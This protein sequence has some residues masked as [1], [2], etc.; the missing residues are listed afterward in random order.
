MNSIDT[1]I[2]IIGAG[3][4][5]LSIA[6]YLKDAGKNVC[7]VESQDRLGGRIQS[8][9]FESNKPLEMGATWFGAQHQSLLSLMQELGVEFFP[10]EFGTTAI[11]DAIST[12]PPFL[13]KL[14]PN[15]T[16]TY[17][18]K[19]GSMKLIT[20]LA[21][22]IQTEKIL[23]NTK[24]DKL[25]FTE[26][27]AQA[28][29]EAIIINAKTIITTLPPNLLVNT[30]NFIPALPEMFTQLAKSTHTWMSESIKFALRFNEAF[31]RSDKLSGTVYSNVGPIP[32]LYD[33]SNFEDNAHALMGFFNGAYHSIQKEERLKMILDQLAKYFGN[34]I[35]EYSSYH[36][37][38]WSKDSNIHY[39]Y[40][41]H[42]IPHQNNGHPAYQASLYEGQ[43]LVSGTET[44]P[45]H[46]GYMEGA[47]F[48]AQKVSNKILES[49]I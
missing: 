6:Y 25:V 3:L 26:D 10:Q 48:T 46:P 13:T 38:V 22:H 20:E 19:G 41:S 11:Y 31:W 7:I 43:L 34:K 1:D 23:L 39:P 12:S 14:P 47:V 40:Q 36:E 49:I 28:F 32:E 15:S 21:Q 5:G 45:K 24:I 2:L 8:E 35:T 18:I 44:S 17:R 42:V 9:D 37:K 16:P 30:I 29:A 4:T 27:K 33:H